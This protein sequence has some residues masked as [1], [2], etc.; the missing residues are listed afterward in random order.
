MDN[1]LYLLPKDLHIELGKYLGTW[2][3]R[4]LQHINQTYISTLSEISRYKYLRLTHDLNPQCFENRIVLLNTKSHIF[5][6]EELITIIERLILHFTLYLPVTRLL[7]INN[8]LRMERGKLRISQYHNKIM[9]WEFVK[10]RVSEISVT[11][12][13]M[14]QKF[15][16]PKSKQ[17][18]TYLVQIAENYQEISISKLIKNDPTATIINLCRALYSV[19]IFN[20]IIFYELNIYFKESRYPLRIIKYPE[21]Y[22]LAVIELD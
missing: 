21:Y 6:E 22:T 17:L 19:K 9:D 7:E 10:L 13:T 12:D 2:K 20:K 15:T 11:T 1:Y 4:V 8:I 14:Y 3:N 18:I 16:I 5:T